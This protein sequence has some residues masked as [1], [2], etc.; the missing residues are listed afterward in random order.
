VTPL[1]LL[2]DEDVD[3]RILRGLRRAHPQIDACTV[4]EVGLAGRPD[5]EILA[6]AATQGRL[7]VTQ[8]VH[9]MTAEHSDFVQSGKASAGVVFI[10]RDVPIGRA[11]S[12]LA[13]ICGAC[14]AEDWISRTDFLPV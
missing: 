2:F 4:L 11:I 13:L 9:T 7:L 1:R 6:W 5:R 10:P 12:D 14:T 3:H 8:D